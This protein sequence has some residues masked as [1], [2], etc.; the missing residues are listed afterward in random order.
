MHELQ[1][2]LVLKPDLGAPHPL[3]LHEVG[4][5]ARTNN[6]HE[7]AVLLPPGQPEKCRLI[8]R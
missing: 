5:A 2:G 4:L 7:R 6:Q 1:E 8:L 3:K